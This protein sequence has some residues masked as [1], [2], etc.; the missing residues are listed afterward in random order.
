MRTEATAAD[1][2]L[3]RNHLASAFA[4]LIASSYVSFSAVSHTKLRINSSCRASTRAYASR[5]VAGRA[6]EGGRVARVEE[7]MSSTVR[8]A[9]SGRERPCS[10]DLR[11]AR[12]RAWTS[13]SRPNA[14][15]SQ[16]SQLGLRDQAG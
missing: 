4:S 14:A 12:W 11:R 8:R 1:H 7:R 10:R 16:V 6:K 15:S 5:P 13:E 3:Q 9:M 2:D